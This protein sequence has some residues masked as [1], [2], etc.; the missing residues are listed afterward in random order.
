[1]RFGVIS[2]VHGNRPALLAIVERLR[3]EGVDAWLSAGD[4]IGYGPHPN[5]CV[6]IVAELGALGVAGN[7][8]LIVLGRLE[9]RSSSR[10]AHTSHEWTADVLRDDIVAYLAG[11]PRRLETDGIIVTHGSLDDPEEYV[12]SETKAL[13]Q[14][15]QLAQERPS[16]RCLIVGNTHRQ[17]CCAEHDG[18]IKIGHRGAMRL[19]PRRRHLLNPGSVGQSRQWEWPP[20][21]RG[22]I[23]DMD[24]ASV[25]FSVVSYDVRAARREL[26]RHGLPYRSIHSVPPLR[27]ALR[28]RARRLGKLL[29]S[30]HAPDRSS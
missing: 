26:G 14:L 16:A 3:G 8:E 28:R 24:R 21:A 12:R 15:H 22:M 25:Q 27:E 7:H 13:Q 19:D 11:L 29:K 17:F 5:E 1:M 30:T 6:E 4:L 2:D 9:G 20:H 18:S 23:V 10:R